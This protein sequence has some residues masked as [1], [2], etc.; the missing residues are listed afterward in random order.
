MLTIKNFPI[1]DFDKTC[2]IWMSVPK[3]INI[4]E[5]KIIKIKLFIPTILCEIDKRDDICHL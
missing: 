1:K 4:E 5:I 2:K 3:K